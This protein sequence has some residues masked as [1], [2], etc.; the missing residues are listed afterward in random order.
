MKKF[1]QGRG[2]QSNA[3]A[4]RL[5]AESIKFNRS[6]G[7]RLIEFF[8]LLFDCNRLAIRLHPTAIQLYS[9]YENPAFAI[10]VFFSVVVTY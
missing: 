8:R 6:I 9:I 2:S 10:L 4:V 7:F 3:I 1:V 5:A